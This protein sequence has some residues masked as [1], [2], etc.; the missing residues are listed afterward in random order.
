M[1]TCVEL[2][3]YGVLG[4]WGLDLDVTGQSGGKTAVGPLGFGF[5]WGLRGC[6]GG[7]ILWTG[8]ADTIFAFEERSV[9]VAGR[10][11]GREWLG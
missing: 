10:A 7:Q 2:S 6:C 5:R 4:L 8:V 9:G 1:G 3:R 11:P